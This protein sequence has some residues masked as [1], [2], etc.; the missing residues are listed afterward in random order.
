M[1]H[2]TGR[3]KWNAVWNERSSRRISG[4][5]ADAATTLSPISA[6]TTMPFRA[7]TTGAAMKLRGSYSE[8]ESALVTR[9]RPIARRHGHSLERRPL[10]VECCGWRA[11]QEPDAGAPYPTAFASLAEMTN[12]TRYAA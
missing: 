8:P 9:I 6:R 7:A 12:W 10:R 11:R 1:T 4:A 2:A 5:L 3:K